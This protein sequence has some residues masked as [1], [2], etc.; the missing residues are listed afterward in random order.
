[1]T[2]VVFLV[3]IA[4]NDR[5]GRRIAVGRCQ[6]AALRPPGKKDQSDGEQAAVGQASRPGGSSERPLVT[7]ACGVSAGQ[8]LDPLAR[9]SV[10][11]ARQ[12]NDVG[13]LV[14]AMA[15]RREQPGNAWK[16][17]FVDRLKGSIALAGLV[18]VRARPTIRPSDA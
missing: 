6:R 5:S 11:A 13:G 9:G 3:M 2:I 10:A 1:M 12:Q 7:G 16:M 8:N 15:V 14:R 18:A 17:S 4:I